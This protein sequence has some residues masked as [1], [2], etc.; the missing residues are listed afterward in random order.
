MLTHIAADESR[1]CNDDGRNE[2]E[3]TCAY[4]L[5]DAQAPWVTRRLRASSRSY[6]FRTDTFACFLRTGSPGRAVGGGGFGVTM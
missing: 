3:P 1:M 2:D 4:V 6:D 5:N